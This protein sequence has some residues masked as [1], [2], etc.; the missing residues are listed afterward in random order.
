MSVRTP[1]SVKLAT[2]SPPG[3]A[4]AACCQFLQS[5]KNAAQHRHATTNMAAAK[6]SD[7]RPGAASTAS[8]PVSSP[9]SCPSGLNLVSQNQFLHGAPEQFLA[10][11]CHSQASQFLGVDLVFGAAI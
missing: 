9:T 1:N 10:A 6:G 2:S 5:E 3:Q 11:K 4:W 8:A 7:C